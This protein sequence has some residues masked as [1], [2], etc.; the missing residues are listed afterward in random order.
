MATK[1][2]NQKIL[3]ALARRRGK[4]VGLPTLAK[5]SGSLSP[6][7]RVSNLRREGHVIENRTEKVKRQG[8]LVTVSSY[9]L[10]SDH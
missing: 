6:A 7:T 10:K 3:N 1:T 5:A 9:R 2:Q 8:Q 4:W